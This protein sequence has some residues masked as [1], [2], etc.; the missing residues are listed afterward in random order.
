MITKKLFDK[1]PECI[2]NWFALNVDYRNNSLIPL[3]LGIANDYSY[4]KY[5]F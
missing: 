4:K 2:S 5:C 3:P 1:K